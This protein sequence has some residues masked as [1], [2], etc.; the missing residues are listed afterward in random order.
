MGKRM[1]TFYTGCVVA[2]LVHRERAHEVPKALVDTG[3]ELSWISEDVLREIGV[4]PEKKDV[5]FVMANGRTISR[6]IGYALIRIGEHVTVDEV[7]FARP[8]DLQIIGARTL[9]GL[10]LAVHPRRK[11]LIAAG[12]SPAAPA[13]L[14]M[15]SNQSSGRA[16]MNSVIRRTHSGSST[17][18]KL[19][20]WERT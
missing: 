12:P 9:E 6:A 4:A 15:S 2:N 17:I 13:Y 20:P 16:A 10:N 8:G 5:P 7:V 18:S 1:G 14:P 3:S 19:T 11:A